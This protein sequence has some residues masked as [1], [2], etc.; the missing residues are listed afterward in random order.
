M[1]GIILRLRRWM[2]FFP[3]KGTLSFILHKTF[4]AVSVG[5]IQEL[6][7]NY[8]ICYCF[9]VY[10]PPFVRRNEIRSGFALLSQ[11][12]LIGSVVL[13]NVQKNGFVIEKVVEN[14]AQLEI[15]SYIFC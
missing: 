11:N 8:L 5:N 12:S 2:F 9:P 13:K 7:D 15:Y 1:I 14:T 6:N 4:A 3:F 10:C